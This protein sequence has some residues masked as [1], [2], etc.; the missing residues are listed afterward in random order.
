MASTLGASQ[1]TNITQTQ[2]SAI[3][4][5]QG[6]VVWETRLLIG[7]LRPLGIVGWDRHMDT[8]RLARLLSLVG[9]GYQLL[10]Q[11]I[12]RNVIKTGA[13]GESAV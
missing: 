10:A 4:I 13:E 1:W 2:I 7:I 11:L 8:P 6:F 5:N 12:N 9:N 3:L